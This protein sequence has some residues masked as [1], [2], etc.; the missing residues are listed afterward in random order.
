[1]GHIVRWIDSG[2][3]DGTTF[4][5]SHFGLTGESANER[6]EAKGNGRVTPSAAPNDLWSMPAA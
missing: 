5:W 6:A 4:E 2:D 3:F 1:M